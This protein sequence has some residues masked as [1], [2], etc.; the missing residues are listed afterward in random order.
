MLAYFISLIFR[1]HTK[2]SAFKLRRAYVKLAWR[3]MGMRMDVKGQAYD[4]AALYVSNHRSFS[5][6]IVASLYVDAFVIAKAEVSNYPFINKGAEL[7]GIIY[8]KRESKESRKATRAAFLDIIKTGYNV[9]VYPE[10]TVNYEKKTLPY[11][12]GTFIEAA[13]NNIPVVPIALEYKDET[14]LWKVKNFVTQFFRQFGKSRTYI[15]MEIGP[16]FSDTDGE[17]LKDK[18]EQWTN[19]RLS[20]MQKNWSS[21]FTD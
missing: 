12:I 14:D 20:S 6:P 18:V 16:A 3:V 11:K 21:V 7:T 9:L 17:L 10:G 19:E 4:G 5:D 15:K 2:E 8:V 13:K 1:K